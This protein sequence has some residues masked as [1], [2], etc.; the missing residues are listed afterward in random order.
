MITRLHLMNFLRH[1]DSELRFDP[2]HQLVVVNGQNGVG[3]SS[4]FNAVLFALYGEA[5]KGRKVADLVMRGREIEGCQVEL[6]FTIGESTY[7]VSRRRDGAKVSAILSINGAPVCEG[8]AA[9]TEQVQHIIGMDAAGFRVAFVAEQGELDGLASLQPHARAKMLAR[10]LRLDAIA[11]AKVEARKLYNDERKIVVALASGVDVAEL[12]ADLASISQEHNL[13]QGQ[14]REAR[15]AVEAL[16]V[17]LTGAADVDAAYVAAL[18]AQ[19][20][21]EAAALSASAEVARLQAEL[22]GTVIPDVGDAPALDATSSN[23]RLME[24]VRDIG[25]AKH[26]QSL[27][28]Q[29]AT[30]QRS[31]TQVEEQATAAQGSLE[32]LGSLLDPADTDATRVATES[33]SAA[34]AAAVA[35]AREA[36]ASL[37]TRAIMATDR[38][39]SFDLLEASCDACGQDVPDSHRHAL[40]EQADAAVTDTRAAVDAARDA[41]VALAHE[42]ATAR[43]A[44]ATAVQIH[45]QAVRDAGQRAML[46]DSIADLARRAGTYAA[47]IERLPTDQPDVDALHAERAE[48]EHAHELAV[49]YQQQVLAR[50]HAIEA[51]D[52]LRDSVTAAAQRADVASVAAVT[53]TV[54][55]DLTARHAEVS[56]AR[57]DRA[58]ELEV[59]AALSAAVAGAA[60]RVIA[61]RRDL[62][63]GRAA[64]AK[65]QVHED[66]ARTAEHAATLLQDVG[67][68]LSTQ[69][70]P[71][72]QGSV[73]D[74]L[75][76]LSAGRFSECEISETY[77]VR[78]LDGD[79][80]VDLASLSGGEQ[81]LVALAVRLGLAEVVANRQGSGG[82]GTLV[83]DE[84][85]GSQD[86]SRQA[87]I[88]QALRGLRDDYGQILLI[89]HVGGLDEAAD[90][91]VTVTATPDRSETEVFLS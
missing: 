33:V 38:R 66:R 87:S 69:I 13:L 45:Q 22:D 15:D 81:D 55:N 35:D 74:L 32:A 41:A 36:L 8:A 1:S 27:V 77:D 67:E 50:S 88:I 19:A 11:A 57:H 56:A 43:V 75:G 80:M 47:T 23:A 76:R 16:D 48:L 46:S 28:E 64:I 26:A 6:E 9:V 84:V 24:V 34:A 79:V 10:L 83:L 44:L 60:E 90:A 65:R 62:D 4:L 71:A 17:T 68:I 18:D 37:E 52:R 2:D 51:R 25:E 30:T 53:A 7:E 91:V 78:V 31:L 70:R 82:I 42:D 73:S 21:T 20:R 86:V 39:A 12:T 49:R 89:S 61:A 85:F 72:L 5:P 29:R 63:R 14:A 58:A 40:L 54:G 3:K 59:L